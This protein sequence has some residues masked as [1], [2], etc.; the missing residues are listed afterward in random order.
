[1]F[2]NAP[3]IGLRLKG[4]GKT[5]SLK[6]ATVKWFKG[7]NSEEI[8]RIGALKMFASRG[9]FFKEKNILNIFGARNK[10][11]GRL[12]ICSLGFNLLVTIYTVFL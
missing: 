1:M 2:C 7:R 4:N 10:D 5:T 6:V 9:P 11:L 3:T 12:W 8:C